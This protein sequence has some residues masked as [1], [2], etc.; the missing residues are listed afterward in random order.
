MKK[1][2][3]VLVVP[4]PKRDFLKE[5]VLRIRKLQESRRNSAEPRRP[6]KASRQIIS[7]RCCDP[8]QSHPQLSLQGQRPSTNLR[9][10]MSSSS[11]PLLRDDATQTS[12]INDEMFLKDTI[13]RFPSASLIRRATSKSSVQSQTPVKDTEVVK[14]PY[15]SHFSNN[16]DE[17]CEK[18]DN[19][20]KDLSEF[21]E[22]ATISKKLSRSSSSILKNS[23]NSINSI[24]SRTKKT[25][26]NEPKENGDVIFISDED[27]V[28]EKKAKKE[29]GGG[30]TA[31]SDKK[32][33]A[34]EIVDPDC[35]EGHVP[36]SESERVEALQIAKK[37]E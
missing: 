26:I 32:E 37:S 3:N 18:M 7:H 2:I 10:S 29:Q 28:T 16:K 5:N 6:C 1:K 14:I 9:K 24:N 27:E 15:Q 11:I 30:D 19:H 35:P 20:V 34:K 31:F 17:H 33:S 21:L 25:V 36:L 12:D 8:K 23:T 13:I 4:P 22:K